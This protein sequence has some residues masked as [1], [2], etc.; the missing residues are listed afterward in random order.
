MRSP[1]RSVKTDPAVPPLTNVS[2]PGPSSPSFAGRAGSGPR[3]VS[4]S[5]RW[6]GSL[7]T[8][9]RFVLFLAIF[10][11]IVG[12]ILGSGT[13]LIA[14]PYAVT[15]YLVVFNRDS[16]YSEPSSILA[17][18]LVVIVS[19]EALELLL[20]VSTLALVLNVGLVSLFIA[21]TR[22]SHP[23]ALALTIFSYI[24]HDSIGFVL[25]SL[26][27]LGIVIVA[28]LVIERAWPSRQPGP[29]RRD[30]TAKPPRPEG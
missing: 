21:F 19:S 17:S 14:P 27:V 30:E 16:R 8:A 10:L 6:P 11:A 18:Y 13:L 29:F 26:V 22:Y 24:V 12:V 28:D 15:A 23:P 20:G 4:A 5:D 1:T 7:G 2:P 9:G 3:E 25:S